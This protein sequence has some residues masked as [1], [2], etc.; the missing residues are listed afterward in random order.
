MQDYIT[1]LAVV[2]AVEEMGKTYW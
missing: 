2:W 1:E